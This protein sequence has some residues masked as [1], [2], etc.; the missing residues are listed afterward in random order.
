MSNVR[1]LILA[2]GFGRRMGKTYPDIPKVMLPIAGKPILAHLIGYMVSYNISE[3]ALSLYHKADMIKQYFNDGSRFGAPLSYVLEQTP[4]GSGGALYEA[5]DF[6]DRTLVVLNG[7][8]LSKVAIDKLLAFH[9]ARSAAA[10]LVVHATP[11]PLDSD[12]IEIDH[13]D[14]VMRIF[15]PKPGNQFENIANAGMFVLEPVIKPY[16]AAHGI[17]SM[18]QDLIPALINAGFPVF[19]YE[20]QEYIK[21]IGTPA[22]FQKVQ[23]EFAGA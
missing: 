22:R 21:D 13:T 20:T 4:R 10:T 5:R 23:K 16:I 7:D 8:V 19:A 18:E 11:H 9:R 2:G 12:M 17:Q 3:I 1:G 6:F 15:R 14:R